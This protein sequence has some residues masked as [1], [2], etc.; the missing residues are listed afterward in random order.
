MSSPINALNFT[1]MFGFGK[2]NPADIQ[3]VREEEIVFVTVVL[4]HHTAGKI[5]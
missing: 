5:I 4:S 2:P 1:E 3:K